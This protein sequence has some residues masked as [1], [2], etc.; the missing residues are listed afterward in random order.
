MKKKTK[1]LKYLKINTKSS[2]IMYTAHT[3]TKL[4]KKKIKYRYVY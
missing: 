2:C 3:Y 1:T 4:K